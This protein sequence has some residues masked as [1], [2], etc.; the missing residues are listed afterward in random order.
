MI[1]HKKQQG[2]TLAE[3]L[4]TIGII[5]VVAGL[6]IPTIISEYQERVL[7]NLAKKNYSL[8]M[9]AINMYNNDNE[10][11]GNY[12]VLMDYCKSNTEIITDF[13]KYFNGA[14][15]CHQNNT[16]N[17]NL[18]YK[19]KT[20]YP[21]NDGNNHNYFFP[22]LDARSTILLADGAYLS[23]R[24]ETTQAGN[25]GYTWYKAVTDENGNFIKN[26]D[27]SNKTI[28]TTASRCGR[29]TVDTNGNKGPNRLGADIFNYQIY[30]NNINFMQSEGDLNYIL[31]NNKIQP[32]KNYSE[33]DF[34]K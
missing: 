6:T 20:P 17:C 9:N 13:M 34:S 5:G 1:I 26:D 16:Q 25:C 31:K 33:G 14:K 4:I 32:H 15:L 2:F 7:V 27:G 3:T 11:I 24:R 18:S 30:I 28:A 29:I 8:V 22:S 23:L 12:S 19:I 21:Q 10:S